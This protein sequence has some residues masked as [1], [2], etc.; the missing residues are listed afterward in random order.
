VAAFDELARQLPMEVLVL[1]FLRDE[2]TAPNRQEGL[3]MP[4]GADRPMVRRPFLSEETLAISVDAF[5]AL[6]TTL[7][8]IE[9][10]Q[11]NASEQQIM[12]ALAAGETQAA[13]Q[14]IAP[15]SEA[16]RRATQGWD[17]ADVL[18][19]CKNPWRPWRRR[20]GRPAADW[21]LRL[22]TLEPI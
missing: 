22:K 11:V 13:N 17:Q 9:S 15:G 12:N 4:D 10:G 1:K 3:P 7:D 5:S 14:G 19:P 6:F 8:W 2:L 21:P 18:A 20:G 16:W